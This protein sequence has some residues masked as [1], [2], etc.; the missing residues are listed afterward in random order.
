[1]V[2][3]AFPNIPPIDLDSVLFLDRGKRAL[4][5]IFDVF[6]PVQQPFYVV[7]F[8]SAEHV[9]GH[10]IDPGDLVCFAPSTEHTN[11]VVIDD[12]MK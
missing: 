1:M 7:R 10:K 2:V 6:G 8:N 11:Y 3:E 4:G 12:L 5:Q 9:R